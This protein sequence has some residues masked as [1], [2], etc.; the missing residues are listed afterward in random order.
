M[1]VVNGMEQQIE[2]S[3]RVLGLAGRNWKGLGKCSKAV[4][5]GVGRL[6]QTIPIVAALLLA[7]Q[8]LAAQVCAVGEMAQNFSFPAASWADGTFGPV[9]YPVVTGG[10]STT[11]TVSVTPNGAVVLDPTPPASPNLGLNGNDPTSLGVQT[12]NAPAGA[13]VATFNFGLSRPVNKLSFVSMDVD[14]YE[15]VTNNVRFRDFVT[16]RANGGALLPTAINVDP[17][18]NTVNLG[19]GT[20]EAVDPTVGPVD[21]NNR[22]GT[23]LFCQLNIDAC[24][25]TTDFSQSGITSAAAVYSE[26]PAI[27]NNQGQRVSVNQFSWCLPPTTVAVTAVSNGGVGPFNYTGDNGYPGETLTT[28]VPATGVTGATQTLTTSATST[29]I[30]ETIPPGYALTGATFTGLGAGGTATPNLA[31]GTVTLDAA[32]TAAGS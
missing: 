1:K 4:R 21:I 25:V 13:I 19:A 31:A 15:D 32:A 9:A 27:A 11:L 17:T 2:G 30:T 10:N 24:N 28:T 5:F 22:R 7:P 29:T 3:R 20:V 8:T 18:R 14:A 23:A 26:S 12:L 6:L 16:Y